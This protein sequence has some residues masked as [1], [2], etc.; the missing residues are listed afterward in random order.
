MSRC[1]VPN[2]PR[3]LPP[4]C[5]CCLQDVNFKGNTAS[6]G[7]NLDGLG[8]AISLVE[9]CVPSGCAQ[10]TASIAASKF[11]TNTALKAGGGLFFNGSTD[12]S[13]LV[14]RW[15]TWNGRQQQIPAGIQAGWCLRLVS[16]FPTCCQRLCT[17]FVGV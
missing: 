10:V 6:G 7:E 13:G 2:R 15:V 5:C 14:V 1:P 9:R 11:S 4:S 12:G 17:Q 8:G 3:I 16:S